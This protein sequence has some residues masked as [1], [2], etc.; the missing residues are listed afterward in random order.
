M[1]SPQLKLKK[2]LNQKAK[3][4]KAAKPPASEHE[5]ELFNSIVKDYNKQITAH[6]R[7][8][9]ADLPILQALGAQSYDQIENIDHL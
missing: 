2:K 1:S 5:M 6:P 4:P 9:N 7:D 8:F 3:D